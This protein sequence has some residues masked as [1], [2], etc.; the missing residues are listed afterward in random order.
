MKKKL[1]RKEE[2]NMSKVAEIIT[3]YTILSD[4]CDEVDVRKDGKYIQETVLVLKNTIRANEG[5]LGL[6][7][8][9]VGR[10][11]RIICLNF[12]GKIKSY[13]NPIITNAK[14]LRM[15]REACHSIPDR[16]F[17]RVRS[18]IVDITYQTPLGKIES[19]SLYGIAATVMQ[20]HIDH[21]DGL[22]LE[23]VGMEVFSDFDE[24]TDEER[25]EVIKMYLDSLDV[26][27]EEMSK[28]L[29]NDEEGKQFTDALRFM[30]SVKNGETIV[31]NV[32]LSDEEFEKLK[33][34]T[35]IEIEEHNAEVLK[36]REN[37]NG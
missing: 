27:A 21:L 17:L 37:G 24:A 9:Q 36:N 13:V 29:E 30:E 32:P 5:M 3:D 31:E 2:P 33:E 1:A 22:L 12:N 19:T 34:R 18:D 16:Q 6:S 26:R 8:N 14:G 28:D 15:S 20:H 7:A 10:K 4:R 35:R 11:G 25:E 23:D